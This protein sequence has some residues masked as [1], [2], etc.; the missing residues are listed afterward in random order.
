MTENVFD[1]TIH[2]AVTVITV[3]LAGN[4]LDL[5]YQCGVANNRIACCIISQPLFSGGLGMTLSLHTEC[6]CTP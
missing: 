5:F 6:Y 2:A 3:V 1:Y 4:E